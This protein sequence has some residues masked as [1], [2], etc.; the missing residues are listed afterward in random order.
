MFEKEDTFDIEEECALTNLCIKQLE[1]IL[2]KDNISNLMGNGSNYDTETIKFKIAAT[3]VSKCK[4]IDNWNIDH[5]LKSL[6]KTNNL[7]QFDQITQYKTELI[8]EL[9]DNSIKILI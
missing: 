6:L 1:T 4:F 7:E 9:L 2:T 3:I 5:L 8:M